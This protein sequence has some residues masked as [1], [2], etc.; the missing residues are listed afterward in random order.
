MRFLK[1]LGLLAIVAAGCR[2]LLWFIQ[3]QPQAPTVGRYVGELVGGALFIFLAAA[4]AAGVAAFVTRGRGEDFPG[5]AAGF[6]VALAV[7]ALALAN[8]G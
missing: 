6:V 7:S 2:S 8:G 4:I 1:V 5:L 3:D